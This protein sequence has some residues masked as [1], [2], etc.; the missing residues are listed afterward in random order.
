MANIIGTT[1]NDTLVS[2]ANID[3]T[4]SGGL[5]DDRYVFNP[6]HG[7][8]VIFDEGGTRDVIALGAGIAPASVRLQRGTG[9]G[10]SLSFVENNDLVIA[11]VNGAGVT[12]S[13][14]VVEDHFSSPDAAIERLRFADG[15]VR[16]L[17][18]GLAISA[19]PGQDFVAGFRLNDRLQSSARNEDL[20]GDLGNDLYLFSDGFGFDVINETGG[21]DTIMLDGSID[22]TRILLFQGA[23]DRDDLAIQVLNDAGLVESQLIVNEHFGTAAAAVE[24]LRIGSR[25]FRIDDLL[26]PLTAPQGGARLVARP[27]DTSITGNIGPDT[28]IAQFGAVTIDGGAGADTIVTGA[29]GDVIRGGAGND[30][31][32]AGAGNDSINGGT[33]NDRISAGSGDDLILGDAGDDVILTGDGADEAEGG[34]GNDTIVGGRGD[35]TLAGQDGADSLNGG[36]GN[37]VINGGAGNDRMAGGPGRDLFEFTAAGFGDDRILDFRVGSDFLDFRGSGVQLADLTI[38]VGSTATTMI[39]ED[40]SIVLVGVDNL[41]GNEDQAFLF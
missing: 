23:N 8:D 33:G 35:Q 6:L 2:N 26:V 7:R 30:S 12:V 11:V 34:L 22:P 10:D 13:Q 24:T 19:V 20:R 14:V 41:V 28:I 3:A 29:R 21:N 39:V 31:V 1:G 4:L 32:T 38:R 17:T 5:G 40:S 18:G 37:D 15:S 36:I 9:G 25:S 27:T 16:N